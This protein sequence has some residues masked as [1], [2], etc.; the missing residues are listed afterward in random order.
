MSPTHLESE[1]L[2]SVAA[3][4]LRIL[5]SLFLL[6]IFRMPKNTS[7][8]SLAMVKMKVT[9]RV[10][11]MVMVMVMVVMMVTVVMV[12]V[13]IVMVRLSQ[14]EGR[15]LPQQLWLPMCPFV[16]LPAASRAH[17]LPRETTPH[18]GGKRKSRRSNLI[19]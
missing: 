11:M 16:Q 17:G 5:L 19:L 2:C 10:V 3:W 6:Q 12:M 15:V 18:A 8:S 4:T 14:G 7:F 13:I 1:Q 9:V